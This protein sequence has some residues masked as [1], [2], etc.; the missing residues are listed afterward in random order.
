MDFSNNNFNLEDCIRIGESL[1]KNHTL[2]G[3]HFVG[4]YGYIDTRGF[5]VIEP[6]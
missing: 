6:N 1:N 5:L 4:N 2:Y 3:F